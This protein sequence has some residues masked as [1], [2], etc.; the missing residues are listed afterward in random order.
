VDVVDVVDRGDAACAPERRGQPGVAVLSLRR[1]WLVPHL[2]ASGMAVRHILPQLG[3]QPGQR[4]LPAFR[5]PLLLDVAHMPLPMLV[6]VLWELAHV[7]E[8]TPTVVLIP[9]GAPGLARLVGLPLAV[10]VIL[11]DTVGA[12]TRALW[13]AM[14]PQFAPRIPDA[15][16]AWVGLVPMPA[17]LPL[18]PF[19]LATLH[20][21]APWGA[22]APASLAAAA[23]QAGISRRLLCY[24]L[25]A[26]RRLVGLPPQRRYHLPALAAALVT[27]LVED[28]A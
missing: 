9:A 12:E 10:N 14:A 6:A 17:P 23:R 22:P 18:P 13:L 1:R 8:R 15:P 16:P 27:A 25:A 24:Q 2:Q 11:A 5:P 28:A 7:R 21:L 20:A 4:L 3:P 26:L 19:T